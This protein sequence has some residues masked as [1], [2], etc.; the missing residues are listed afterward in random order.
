ME[1]FSHS[2]DHDS[3]ESNPAYSAHGRSRSR[4]P[5]K[6]HKRNHSRDQGSQNRHR[7][8]KCSN[9]ERKSSSNEKVAQDLSSSSQDTLVLNAP[10]AD[11]PDYSAVSIK[12]EKLSSDENSPSPDARHRS[13]SKS[14]KHKR[15]HKHK[16]KNKRAKHSR[17]DSW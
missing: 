12:Q 10:V 16:H 3:F 2:Q 5:K 11:L 8:W 14:I 13:G 1:S 7:K 6:V 15:K 9:L 4:S 17:E